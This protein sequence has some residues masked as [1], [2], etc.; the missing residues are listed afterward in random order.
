[1]EKIRGIFFVLVVYLCI[2]VKSEKSFQFGTELMET[3]C[4][5]K[6]N[7]SKLCAVQLKESCKNET[8]LMNLFDASSKFPY[9]G[10][11][12]STRLDW[13]NFDQCMA[14]DHN[15]EGGR[16]LGKYCLSG[17]II[18]DFTN[19][20]SDD[21][22]K[23]SICIPDACSA[24]DYKAI[25]R[26]L[27]VFFQTG[28]CVT[29]ETGTEY[30]SGDIVTL[31]IFGAVGILMIISTT[32]DVYLKK[33]MLKCRHPMLLA[34]SVY[35]N[36]RKL[37]QTSKGNN[38]EQILCF[39]GMKIISMMWIVLGHGMGGWMQLPITNKADVN[40]AVQALRSFWMTAAPIA[41]ETFFYISGFLT[42]YLY[43]KK[44]KKAP[45]AVQIKN[46]PF[47]YIHRYFRLTPAVIMVYILSITSFSHLGS[48][49][50]WQLGVDYISKPCRKFWWSFFL[51]I[52]N[53]V[54]YGD[55]DICLVQTWYLS[56]DM[57]MFVFT[58]LLLIPLAVLLRDT[59][60]LKLAMISLALLNVIVTAIPIAIKYLLKNYNNPY[61]THTRL[62]S[63]T[64]G[65]T[66]GTFMRERKDKPFLYNKCVKHASIVNFIIWVIVLLGMTA[67]TVCYQF[68]ET[69]YSREH[70]AV[71]VAI[72]RLAWAIGL[73]WMV[74]SSYH[75]YGGIV[76]WILSRPICQIGAKLSYCIYVIHGL[77]VASYTFSRREKLHFSYYEAVF[78]NW[79]YIMMSVIIAFCWT[80]AFESP[81]MVL[82]KY[83][84]GGTNKKGNAAES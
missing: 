80:M 60:K 62:A 42:V 57:Q 73:S 38:S 10:L 47:L 17:L 51:Y 36:G 84:F 83:V 21:P 9:P 82:E 20:T 3:I 63:Y 8:V 75:G 44:Q 72:A 46:I 4:E 15:F 79:G 65:I 41:V 69:H 61:D 7:V 49:P 64:M 50:I 67:I 27:P 55:N 28:T 5:L 40:L 32:Y 37:L 66:M 74:Y 31:T 58:P 11:A 56:A 68:V 81:L 14:I 1:M 13:G 78:A 52:Q 12:V 77:V 39:Q 33:K 23:L 24:N 70:Q 71:F 53:Y 59:T 76:N 29:K 2:Q 25:F 34:F 22:Y 19:A 54:N 18:P 16:I 26:K 30:T 48:G 6:T 45:L 43:L 35:T